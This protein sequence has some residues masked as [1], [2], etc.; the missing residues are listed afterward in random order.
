MSRFNRGSDGLDVITVKKSEL[1]EKLKKNRGEHSETFEKALKG[2][3]TKVIESLE[4]LLA[5]ARKGK[6]IDHNVLSRLPV[7]MN[8][9]KDYDQAILMLQMH[10]EET[11]EITNEQFACFVMDQWTWRDAMVHANSTY[12]ATAYLGN[13]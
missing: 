7:P 12:A 1:L 3:Q 13:A 10:Q 6:A 9:T 5:D 11:I 2:Y 4:H 8:Q